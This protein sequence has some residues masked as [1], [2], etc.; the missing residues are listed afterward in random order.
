LVKP[1]LAQCYIELNEKFLKDKTFIVDIDN[2]ETV[3]MVTEL[4]NISH[5]FNKKTQATLHLFLKSEHIREYIVNSDLWEF[6]E[7]TFN[8]PAGDVSKIKFK[9]MMETTL[10]SKPSNVKKQKI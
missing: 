4:R 1:V 8:Y 6:R 10:E 2:D 7:K 3:A 5:Q 9:Q